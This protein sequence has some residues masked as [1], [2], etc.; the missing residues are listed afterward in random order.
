MESDSLYERVKGGG[1]G[2]GCEW[3]LWGWREG[4]MKRCMCLCVCVSI[5]TCVWVHAHLS[6]HLSERAFLNR[7][8]MLI[9]HYFLGMVFDYSLSSTNLISMGICLEEQASLD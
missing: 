8:D 9:C 6:V 5:Y 1:G 7:Q 4:R 2:G 3:G